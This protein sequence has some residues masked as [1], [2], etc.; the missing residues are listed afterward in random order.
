MQAGSRR[1]ETSQQL[2]RGQ[3]AWSIPG[4]FLGHRKILVA[5]FIQGIQEAY[6]PGPALPRPTSSTKV[7][8][9]QD[10]Q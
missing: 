3:A 4:L 10:P 7:S 5:A 2:Q 8:F 6:T 9:V 1:K